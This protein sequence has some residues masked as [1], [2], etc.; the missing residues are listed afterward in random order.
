MIYGK[1]FIDS[2]R[3]VLNDSYAKN[4]N[5]YHQ[6]Q[7]PNALKYIEERFIDPKENARRGTRYFGEDRLGGVSTLE[8]EDFIN[9]SSA[10]EDMMR[11]WGDEDDYSKR[12]D[13]I[14][15]YVDK[16]GFNNKIHKDLLGEIERND[17]FFNENPI[18]GF[19]NDY[20]VITDIPRYNPFNSKDV[21]TGWLDWVEENQKAATERYNP[22]RRA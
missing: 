2:L 10:F 21:R 13:I 17:V 6:S 16:Y 4:S 14:Q 7:D 5:I 15:R 11:E 18:T 12:Q 9:N 22:Y 3:D 20:D 1:N 8:Y 19:E